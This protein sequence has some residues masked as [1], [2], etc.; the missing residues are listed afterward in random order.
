MDRL[1]AERERGGAVRGQVVAQVENGRGRNPQRLQHVAEQA[2]GLGHAVL[3]G[4]E[5]AVDQGRHLRTRGGVEQGAQLGFRNVGVADDD[6]LQPRRLGPAHQ[7]HGRREGEAVARFGGQFGLDGRRA[8]GLGGVGQEGGVD[9]R[10]RHFVAARE[11][12]AAAR[13]AFGQHA[14]V[15]GA[16]GEVGEHVARPMRPTPKQGVEAVQRQHAHARSGAIQ[17]VGKLARCDG[18]HDRA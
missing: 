10:D 2:A 5:H 18:L 4:D 1:D 15:G 6:H 11:F 17:G 16:A 3:G 8:V 7:F 12:G 13:G 9:L 14:L